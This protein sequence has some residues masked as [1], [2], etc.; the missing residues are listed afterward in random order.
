MSTPPG[1]FSSD[2]GAAHGSTAPDFSAID[3]AA[4][5]IDKSTLALIRKA[6]WAGTMSS[7]WDV[8][9]DLRDALKLLGY[10]W[11]NMPRDGK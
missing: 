1:S 4:R 3:K 9:F 10:D 7:L 5:I 11:R 6:E 8:V 2:T